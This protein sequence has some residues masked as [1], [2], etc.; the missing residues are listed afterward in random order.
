[1]E[2]CC[3]SYS[4]WTNTTA[5]APAGW[6]L[7]QNVGSTS[8]AEAVWYRFAYN[9][10]PGSTYTWTFSGN[11][12]EAGA[13][14]AYRGVAASVEDGYCTNS[15]SSTHPSLCS[16]TTSSS[17]DEYVG[18]F[19]AGSTGLSLPSD[20][21][22]RVLVQLYSGEHYGT[23]AAD[24]TLGAP[25]TIAADTGS[26]TGSG[27]WATIAL[28][29]K[30]AGAG[31][32]A[33][34]TA[35]LTATPTATATLI[36]GTIAFVGS[37]STT[38]AQMTV[39]TG[40][41][42]GDLLLASYSYWTNTT[43][44]APAGWQ[45]LQNLGS[46]NAAEA[47]WYR[48]AYNDT[49][50]ST[51]TWTFSGNSEEAGAMLAYRGVA[52]SVEDGYCTNSGSSTHPSLCSFTTSSSND[53][54]V[55][56][57][58]AG[59]TGLSLPSD[60]TTR[61]LVQLYS[62]ENYGT[63]AADKTLGAPGTIA[64]DTGSMTGSGTWATIALALKPAAP[65]P[66]ATPTATLTATATLTPTV[67]ATAT[68]TP[69][70]TS[71]P[72]RTATATPT[73]TLTATPTVT[74]TATATLTATP[75]ATLTA[76]P[77]AT[78]TATSTATQTQ[79]ATATPTATATA[80]STTTATVTPT[81]TATATLTSTATSTATPTGSPTG[82]A[83]PGLALYVANLSGNNVTAYPVG[84]NG[85][86]SP[87]AAGT[88]L[89]GPAGIARDS[90]GNLY[91]VNENTDSVTVYAPGANGN[92]I[93]IATIGGVNTGLDVPTGIALDSSNNIYVT[94]AGS[95][96][97]DADSVTMY[98]S[99]NSG[100][101]APV[102]TITGADTGLADPT[103]IGLDSSGNLY[104]A[105]SGDQ[106]GGA[107]SVTVYTAG[108]NGD[109]LPSAT[110]SGSSTGLTVPSGIALDSS[111]NIYV[112]NNGSSVG[113][114]DSVT[115]YASGS[116]GNVAPSIT[117]SGSNTGLDSPGGIAI[118]S[119]GNLY[120]TNDGSVFGGADS[121]TVYAPASNGNAV[122]TD[123][124][125]ALGLDTPTGIAVDSNG[126]LYVANDGSTDGDVDTVT[127]YPLNDILPSAT[128]GSDTGLDQPS[129][130]ALD[131]S[132][133]I[134]V[135]NQGS[136][137]GGMDSVTVYLPGSY[138]N[139]TAN[140]TIVGSGTSLALPSGLATDL[141]E[142]LYVANS[143][144]GPD[145]VGSITV[146]ASGSNGNVA[147]SITISGD[148]NS[149]TT[150]L[151]F[152]TGLAFDAAGNLYVANATGGP[153]GFGS[154]TI[155]GPGSSGNVT[156]IATIGDDPSCAP[157]DNTELS[158]PLGVA[159]DSSGNIYV[160]NSAG[161]ADGNG[162]VTVYPPLGNGTGTLNEPPNTTI[163]GDSISD[164]N[165]GLDVPSGIALDSAGNIYVTNNGSSVGATDSIAAYS[166]GS[167]GNVAPSAT[168]TGVGT[169]LGGPQ[170]VAIGP[171]GGVSP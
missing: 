155:Y 94:N 3:W 101:V 84:S 61:V 76:T 41:Q 122:P 51:Y 66:T 52:A 110:I 105:N 87:L 138:A 116:N 118:D 74:A 153:D 5:T 144:G 108:S 85:N 99:G 13:M 126:N 60:M 26:M 68:L 143:A 152:P 57:F 14:L 47:V 54:Y 32:T 16:F 103:S 98:A 170:G 97:G 33:T 82:T 75:T 123:T 100:N 4:Y 59:G 39:P 133:N 42:N 107:D 46:T 131:S 20:L 2:T 28:A 121:I 18:L 164:D 158:L 89:S 125:L 115:I 30:P 142:N 147:P 12:E 167:S 145:G 37:T 17:N 48:F 156:P 106:I 114:T 71:T 151:N 6:Q 168:I 112:V 40:V 162:S 150:G 67:T 8:A 171:G 45:L 88:G 7:L 90:S 91:V 23:G 53:E 65:G 83:T 139:M 9:D 78:L 149:D 70:I 49:P 124:L 140:A 64:A 104:V 102:L 92:V 73:T 157:C 132:G 135:T 163:S 21:T 80:T 111:N 141:S 169:G 165:T 113:V 29:L 38:N 15:G 81:P 146:Y 62:G 79:T 25:G 27:T 77:T 95:L 55:G 43:A 72:T 128:I 22:T 130:I 148:S 93:P 120:I 63:G 159:L 36:P 127:V 24:K 56:L 119:G 50:G 44:T 137:T 160:A 11:S 1:M 166:A 10:T 69:T 136:T 134:Y 161:G 154:I 31:P 86:V 109:A 96:N 35:T 58:A 34:P 19:A 129:G 117:I